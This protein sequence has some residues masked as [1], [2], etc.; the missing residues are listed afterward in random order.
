[1]SLVL[2]TK[3]GRYGIIDQ[4]SAQS[5]PRG[6]ASSALNWVTQGDQIEIR[7]G[8]LY[9]GTS[10]INTGNGRASGLKKVTDSQGTEHLVGTYGKKVKYYDIPT[11]EWIEIGSNALGNNVVDA[12]GIGQEDISIEEYVGLAG[13]QFFISS[14]NC[15][16]LLKFL[17]ASMAY[18][19]QY[20]SSKNFI[21]NIKIDSNR[22]MLWGTLKDQTGLY[23]SYIDTQ[24]YATV[25]G[26]SYGTGDGSTK[27]FVH[28]ASTISGKK[29]LFGLTVTAGAITLT[30]NY[31]G[32]L[33]ASDGSTGTVNY[34]TGAISVTFAT[35]PTN[36]LGITCSY[37]TEDSTSAGIADFTKSGTRTAGQG[38]VFRQDEGGGAIKNVK[39]LNGTYYCMH[40]KKTWALTLSSDDT[41]ATNL[42][43]R[44]NVG[45]PSL[46]GSVETGG[47][48]FYIDNTNQQDQRVR[49]LTYQTGGSQQVIPVSLSQNF[50]IDTYNFDK[51]AGIEWGDYVLFAVRS[52]TSTI[53]DRVI[54][55]NKIWKSWDVLDY[56]VSCF[57]IY[58]GT[59]VAGDSA[60]NNFQT[61][62][63]GFDDNGDRYPNYWIGGLDN[64]LLPGL[65]GPRKFLLNGLKKVY[66]FYIR[67]AIQEQQK[68]KISLS[69][70]D[71]DFVEI[72]GSDVV[73]NGVTVHHYAIEGNGVYVDKSRPVDIGANTLGSQLIGGQPGG[74]APAVT[75]NTYERLFLISTDPFEYAQIKYEAMDLGF[76]SVSNQKW[77]DVRLM[78]TRAPQKYT[79]R[80]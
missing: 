51:A 26:E 71:G 37:Q 27:T 60:S 29:T 1:M 67:G 73:V 43:Y 59:L 21:G 50:K 48:V 47:G 6:S 75:A 22:M 8:S 18:V 39:V 64:I 58:N 69:F 30:D 16:G 2:E 52:A 11:A 40:I 31:N 45:S 17:T 53:N 28:T 23:G 35:A 33:S 38:F 7:R 13:N 34:V 36:A 77:W 68:L 65:K 42:P 72:G 20:D 79:D 46:R 19:D 9:L 25:T 74:S 55:Y 15:V 12:N 61:L 57:A 14:P 5:I 70:D 80:M 76:V 32:V 41:N 4:V 49:M 54:A 3:P 56:T 24:N 62:F 10:S 78:G 63:S 44:Q 66:K